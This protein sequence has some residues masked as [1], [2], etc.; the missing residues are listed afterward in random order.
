[1]HQRFRFLKAGVV[2]VQLTWD[3]RYTDMNLE[4]DMPNGVKDIKDVCLPIEH[5]SV[6]KQEDIQTGVYKVYIRNIQGSIPSK[7]PQ[8]VHLAI[9][10]PTK[11]VTF[12]FNITSADM[13]NL[14]HVADIV[15]SEQKE[16]TFIPKGTGNPPKVTHY[17]SGG[18]SGDGSYNSYINNYI[19]DI[20]SR[21]KQGLLGPLSNAEV[22]IYEANNTD[23]SLYTT[24]TTGGDSP[25]TAGVIYFPSEVL[26]ALDDDKYYVVSIQGGDD[27]DANDDGVVDTS[28]TPNG[29][30]IRAII[31]GGKLKRDNF[32]VNI[33]SEAVYQLS[34]D[35]LNQ[36]TSVISQRL[37]NITKRLLLNDIDGDNIINYED[38]F[39]WM[40][41]YDKDKLIKDYDTNYEPVVQKIYENEDIYDDVYAIA[42][43]IQLN[44][45]TLHVKENSATNTVVGKIEV[46]LYDGNTTFALQGEGSENFSIDDEGVVKV[47]TGA[48]LDYESKSKYVFNLSAT[49]D[50]QTLLATLTINIDNE[51]DAPELGGFGSYIDENSVEDT[52]VG[53]L[54]VNKGISEII[55]IR[56]QGNG[57]E[58][59]KIDNAGVITV[60]SGAVL[61]YESKRVYHIQ[62]VATNSEG[63]SLPESVYVYLNDMP[64]APTLQPLT[65]TID[66]NSP[67]DTTVGTISINNNGNA[68]SSITLSGDGSE[69]FNVDN[70][71][72]IT[73]ASGAVLDYETKA[74]YALQA[75]ATNALGHSLTRTVTINLNNLPDTPPTIQ[76]LNANIDE[77]SLEGIVVETIDINDNGTP[78]TSVTLNGDGKEKFNVDNN[79]VITVANGAVLDY[80]TKLQYVLQVV[81]ENSFGSSL[82]ENLIININNLPEP[83]IVQPLTLS[84][85]EDTSVGIMIGTLIINDGG[86]DITSVILSEDGSENFMINTEGIISI[87]PNA[88][89][90]YAIIKKYN[91]QV[92]ASNVYGDSNKADFIVK[93]IPKDMGLFEVVSHQNVNSN[94]WRVTVKNTK[95]EEIFDNVYPFNLDGTLYQLPNG[96]W[97]MASIG[98]TEIENTWEEQKSDEV[99][100]LKGTADII[101][102]YSIIYAISFMHPSGYISSS[103]NKV[104][105]GKLNVDF[106]TKNIFNSSI[107]KT[108]GTFVNQPTLYTMWYSN[109]DKP[110]Y[111]HSIFSLYE[112]TDF[113]GISER[114]M[115]AS[116]SLHELVKKLSHISKMASNYHSD[117]NSNYNFWTVF[118]PKDELKDEILNLI[119]MP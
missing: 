65:A 74:I 77:N 112:N 108:L 86:G 1:M 33:L 13:L 98:G 14:G 4:V 97:V 63:E 2:N 22:N 11:A 5:F 58:N 8:E 79:G 48:V 50:T 78:V 109:S 60:A 73:V 10:T 45:Q 30:T 67:A 57:N 69:K 99:L 85:K 42:Y 19:Y 84:I 20:I 36:D 75:V 93:I 41:M 3:D 101:Y 32:K 35:I 52:Y 115:Y 9:D 27:I 18:S 106:T 12:D 113:S 51:L 117:L 29:G 96:E 70:S 64:D 17:S 15:I 26:D 105:I 119:E 80:E 71:G 104:Y 103:G 31:K 37:E 83:P 40:P 114:Y 49:T 92:V 116:F 56:L 82:S 94:Q 54:Y 91:L 68:V 72:A 118:S 88:M 34:K 46:G 38:I 24:R 87:A 44:N 62:A 102:N 39:Y 59:F 53:Q 21:L 66:E 55:D 61:D 90:D 7:I 76:P 110:V 25:L 23:D 47:N 100:R 81:A 43:D 111:G 6:L 16:A 107:L 28:A 95:T 89:L